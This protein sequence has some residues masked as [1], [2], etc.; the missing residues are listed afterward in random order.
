[1][2][3]LAPSLGRPELRGL[4]RR[5]S[6]VPVASYLD[7]SELRALEPRIFGVLMVSSVDTPKLQGLDPLNLRGPSGF[8]SGYP[9]SPGPGLWISRDPETPGLH[10]IFGV[11]CQVRVTVGFRGGLNKP[12]PLQ[13][14]AL[15]IISEL[16]PIANLEKAH[17][18]LIPPT[19]L[20]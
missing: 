15:T 17:P 4:D 14:S 10:R 6:G 12:T 13:P 1:M 11:P 7:I 9:G 2:H 3:P 5:T 8:D 18:P 19:K 20:H 16:H